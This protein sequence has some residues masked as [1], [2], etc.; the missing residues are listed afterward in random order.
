MAELERKGLQ[1]TEKEEVREKIK[2]TGIVAA[3]RVAVLG[4][5]KELSIK[6]LSRISRKYRKEANEKGRSSRSH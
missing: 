2:E 5:R 1:Q 6:P 4:R 3:I